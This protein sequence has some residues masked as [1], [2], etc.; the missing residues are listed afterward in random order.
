MLKYSL[1]I[2]ILMHGLIHFMGFA[3]AFGYGNITQLTKDIS[4][5]AGYFWLVSALLFIISSV[6]LLL[7]KENWPLIAIIA[8]LMSQVLIVL[9]WKDAK[10]GTI[11]NALILFMAIIVLFYNRGLFK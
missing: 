7:K 8:V 6:L 11:A 1:A 5:P 3:K 4:N 9:V 2:I 10:F